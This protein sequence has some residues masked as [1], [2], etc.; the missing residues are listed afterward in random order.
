[1]YLLYSINVDKHILIKIIKFD[2]FF[3]E[4]IKYIRCIIL[5]LL[6]SYTWRIC[7]RPELY[8]RLFKLIGRVRRKRVLFINNRWREIGTSNSILKFH[9]YRNRPS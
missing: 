4:H 8:M 6:A 5:D 2:F 1:M 7:Y 9:D 3:F